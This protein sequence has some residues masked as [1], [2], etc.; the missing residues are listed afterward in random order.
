MNRGLFCLLTVSLVIA[1]ACAPSDAPTFTD[2]IK[3]VYASCKGDSIRL[4][5]AEKGLQLAF[6]PCGSNNFSRF[7]W[8]PDGTTLYYQASQGG[9]VMR[10]N[11]ENFP[12]RGVHPAGRPAWINNEILAYP[13]SKGSRIGIYQVRAHI[14][15]FLDIPQVEAEQLV[16]GQADDE[17]LFLAADIPGG[18]KY[19]QRLRVNTTET[20]RA[21]PWMNHGVESFHYRKEMDVVCYREFGGSDVLCAQGEDGEEIVEIKDRKRGTMSTDGRFVITEGDGEAIQVSDEPDEDR[22][23][24]LP[25]EI[26]P[27]ALWISNIKSGET[28]PWEGVNGSDFEWYEASPYY[29]SFML[30]GFDGREVKR[31]IPIGDLRAYLRSKGWEV[32]R[33]ASSESP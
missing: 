24:F 26:I 29:G 8:S 10:E 20:E 5:A 3:T 18:V 16:R 1:A 30:W 11:G 25:R 28:L 7:T 19:I 4:R 9:W 12:L 33:S 6:E 14:V 32:S 2:N 21:F 27:P 31:N 15:S 17:V 23:A 13:A 22:A